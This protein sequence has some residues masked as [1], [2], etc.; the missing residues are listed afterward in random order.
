MSRNKL[1]K[2]VSLELLFEYFDDTTSRGV[3]LVDAEGVVHYANPKFYQLVGLPMEHSLEGLAFCDCIQ[4]MGRLSIND[5][6]DTLSFQVLAQPFC[7][8]KQS[9]SRLSIS[10]SLTLSLSGRPMVSGGYAFSVTDVTQTRRAFDALKRTNR[11]TVIALADLAESRDNNTGEH[12]LRV[13]RM[14]HEIA[15]ELR[16]SEP[17]VA[18]IINNDTLQTIG[19]ASILHDV[20]KVTT[21]DTILLKPGPLTAEERAIMQ[22]HA[23]AGYEIINRINESLLHQ[24]S[25]SLAARIAVSHHEKYGGGGYP[26]GVVG[27]EIPIEGRIVAVSDVYDALTSWR[28]YKEPWLVERARQ[29]VRDQVDIMFD[30]KVVLAF[31][32]IMERRNTQN[33]YVWTPSMSVGVAVLDKDHRILLSLAN[34]L[35][36]SSQSNDIVMQELV[37][38]ELYNYTCRHFEREEML[39]RRANYVDLDKHQAIH[40]RMTSKVSDLRQRFFYEYDSRLSLELAELLGR[41]LNQHIL[42]EDFQYKPILQAADIGI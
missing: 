2:D 3:M 7:E 35:S 24:P 12:V 31:E 11:A 34:Q 22:K 30:P 8:L 26:D 20:G 29:F 16:N 42:V 18:G 19:V 32:R 23:Q 40:R 6:S 33:A 27:E 38:E 4:Q 1:S 39:L 17:Q 37:I 25:F 28:P 13:A 15:V 41:W 10:P 14:A 36:V 9:I 5:E 21:P